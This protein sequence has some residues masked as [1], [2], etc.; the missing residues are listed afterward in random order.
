MVCLSWLV[1]GVS[2]ALAAWYSQWILAA[3]LFLGI[4]AAQCL[5]I[6]KFPGHRP[7]RPR[8]RLHAG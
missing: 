6:R 8:D 2:V 7:A 3:L 4:P 1:Y 5:Y